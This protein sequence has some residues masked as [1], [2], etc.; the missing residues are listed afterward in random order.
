MSFLRR[1]FMIFLVLSRIGIAAHT[2][3]N[4][5]IQN[6]RFLDMGSGRGE[7]VPAYLPNPYTNIFYVLKNEIFHDDER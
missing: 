7:G 6:I 4:N 3:V 2:L 5:E 1:A